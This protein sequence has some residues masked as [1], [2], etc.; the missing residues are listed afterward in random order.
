MT[1][2]CLPHDVRRFAANSPGTAPRIAIVNNAWDR[3]IRDP[4]ALLA[5]YDTLTGWAEALA[6]AGAVQV[7]VFQRCDR[8]ARIVDRGVEY[9][10]C[11]EAD[12]ENAD[13]LVEA[14]AALAPDIVHV[15][16]LG[17][18]RLVA[19]LRGRLPEA[20]LVGQDH[21][22]GLP[23]GWWG[24]RR[25]RR[26]LAHLDGALFTAR[27]QAE[28]WRQA[29]VL[30]ERCL[31]C[32]VPEAS[33][34]LEPL[35]REEARAIT[36]LTGH[37]AILWV[38]RLVLNKDPLTVLEGFARARRYLPEADLTMIYRDETLLPAIG[39]WLAER[40]AV[41]QRVHLRGE[42]GRDQIAAFYSAADLFVLGSRR[43]G[44]GYALLE[45]L[46]CGTLPVV[47]DIPSFRALTDEGRC[48]VLWP[49]GDAAACAAALVLGADR[50]G[51]AE[52]RRLSQ[53]F[54]ERLSWPA[55]GSRA[56]ACYAWM[57][58]YRRTNP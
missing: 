57:C 28:P 16:G 24:R 17:A 48:A 19:A 34:R 32:E 31:V 42:V 18:P 55:V 43:E 7:V 38:G 25:A 11:E 53:Y 15:N 33:S 44:S 9:V 29:G 35:A 51:E 30:A 4:Q 39:A 5:R 36:G 46:A 22:D 27:E 6:L 3:T 12:S 8:T 45:A 56:L 14:V 1:A 50:A 47:A 20:I 49:V 40:P 13:P 23:G 26:G 41:S 52:R 37:P 21:A 58:R 2:G 54:A 10:M